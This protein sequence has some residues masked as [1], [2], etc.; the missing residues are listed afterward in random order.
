MPPLSIPSTSKNISSSNDDNDD[1]N[2]PPPS[3]DPP[4]AP[5]LPKWVCSTWDVI[6]ALVSDLTDQ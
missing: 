2:P 6:G 5:Q 1:D 4:S 3:Q